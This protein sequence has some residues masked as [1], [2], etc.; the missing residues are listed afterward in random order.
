MNPARGL[1]RVIKSML[2]ATVVTCIATTTDHKINH[3]WL[4][5]RAWMHIMFER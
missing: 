2:G 1:A 3:S 5:R 4:P